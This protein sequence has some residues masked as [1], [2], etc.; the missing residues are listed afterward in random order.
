MNT[1]TYVP[2]PLL[3][4]LSS[5]AFSLDSVCGS[6]DQDDAERLELDGQATVPLRTTL[7]GERSGKRDGETADDTLNGTTGGGLIEFLKLLFGDN[8]HRRLS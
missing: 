3:V 8:L 5:P 1:R 6:D 4:K 2:I 7:E